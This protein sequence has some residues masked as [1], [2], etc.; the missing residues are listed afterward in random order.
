MKYQELKQ[1]QSNSFNSFTGIFFAFSNSQ[2]DEGMKKMNCVPGDLCSVPGGGFLLKSKKDDFRA[3]FNEH[4]AE[5]TEAMKDDDFLQQAIEY[6]LGN[7]EFCITYDP[8]DTIEAL[9]LDLEDER[10]KGIFA[11]ARRNYLAGCENF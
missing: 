9:S 2:L 8:T 4:D 7:H 3:M 1:S 11:K 6:E 5:M 10:T